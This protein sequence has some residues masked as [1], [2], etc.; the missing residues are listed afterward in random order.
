MAGL[1]FF[2][3]Q[4]TPVVSLPDATIPGY[5]VE[6]CQSMI[7]TGEGVRSLKEPISPRLRENRYE[8]M[9]G[10]NQTPT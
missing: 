9:K 10:I 7:E 3:K 5:V 1:I 6:L 4:G 2:W 8:R